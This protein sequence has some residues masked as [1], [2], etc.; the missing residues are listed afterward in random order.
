M[1]QGSSRVRPGSQHQCSGA[2][3]QRDS[4]R[5]SRDKKHRHQLQ[6]FKALMGMMKVSC[7]DI[8]KAGGTVL[9]RQGVGSGT[10]PKAT[11]SNST[12]RLHAEG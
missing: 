6:I 10:T 7:G 9:S 4:L 11:A 2:P 5:T 1:A 8:R 12:P 3:L